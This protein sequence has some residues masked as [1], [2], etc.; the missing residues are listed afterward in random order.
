M[1]HHAVKN[2]ADCFRL[3]KPV[4]E[5]KAED[6]GDPNPDHRA[7][8][9]PLPSV[10]VHFVIPAATVGL[11]QNYLRQTPLLDLSSAL[12]GK[13]GLPCFSFGPLSYDFMRQLY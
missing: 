8:Q 4:Y 12:R 11:V 13:S 7:P 10:S 1:G 2:A 9:S 6:A 5:K 3:E